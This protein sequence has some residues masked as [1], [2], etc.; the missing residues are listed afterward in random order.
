[1]GQGWGAWDVLGDAGRPQAGRPEGAAAGCV[2]EGGKSGQ[3]A[4]AERGA[5][6]SVLEVLARDG[7]R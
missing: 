4:A 7:L 5:G 3:G 1:V 2:H 6:M